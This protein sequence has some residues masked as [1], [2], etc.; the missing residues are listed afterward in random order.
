VDFADKVRCF[1]NDYVTEIDILKTEGHPQVT[2]Q[3]NELTNETKKRAINVTELGKYFCPAFKGIGNSINYFE[4]FVEALETERTQKEFAQIAALCY[5]GV[6]MNNK[7]PNTFKS[8]YK[9]FCECVGCKMIKSY[10]PNKLKN[11]KEQIKKQFNY[12]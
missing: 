4:W 11:P 6:K 8:W 1:L 5:Y 3:E 9:I 2:I 7:K 12:L 10:T